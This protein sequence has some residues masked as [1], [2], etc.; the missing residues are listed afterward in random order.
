MSRSFLGKAIVAVAV[1]GVQCFVADS[2]D[3]RCC[4]TRRCCSPRITRS[5]CTTSCCTTSCCATP[6]CNTCNTC[7]TCSSPCAVEAAPIVVAAPS[8][9][10]AM[11]TPACGT[12]AS[13][14]C[15]SC[16]TCCA[17]RGI[18]RRASCCNTGCCD[19]GCCNSGCSGCATSACSTCCATPCATCSSCNGCSNIVTAGMPITTVVAGSAMGCPS[20]GCGG[21]DSATPVSHEA[22]VTEGASSDL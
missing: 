4:R 14:N 8:C 20:G 21:C 10:C 22:T 7:N 13:G 15:N 6:V 5:C 11:S 1:L 3:A 12:C 17:R 16:S 2:A 9:G 18:F 19:S